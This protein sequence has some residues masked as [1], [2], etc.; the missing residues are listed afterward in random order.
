MIRGLVAGISK[1]ECKERALELL[2]A[3]GLADKAL[4]RPLSLSGGQQQRVAL[5][6]AIFS[7]PAFL[8]ADEPTGSLD[9]HTGLNIVELLLTL[10][11]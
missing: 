8:L 9:E 10:S 1:A 5:A 3:S 2:E 4:A 11:A 6:R 7:K